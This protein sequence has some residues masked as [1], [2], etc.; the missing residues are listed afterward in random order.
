MVQAIETKNLSLSYGDS[1]II[2]ELDL[3]IPKGEITVF[4]GGN[5]C[6]KSTL[7]RSIARLL[8]PK[9]GTVLL[10]GDA[11]A[12]LSTKE[13]ARRMAILPQSPVAPEGLTVLQL[14][15]QGRYPYQSWLRQWS[16]EDE[17]K[18]EK[19]LKATG[20]T[21]LKDRS[22]DSLSGGQ[23]QRAWIAM[24]LAQDTDILLLDEPTTY[25]DLTHQIEILDLLFELNEQ[26]QRTIVM[27]L[28]D[29]N[30]A[31]RY[32]HNIVAIKDQ[33]IFAEGKPETVINCS[34]V[35]NVFGMDCEVTMDPL[36]GTP[37]CI[38]Y[39]KGRCIVKKVGAANGV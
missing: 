11:I 25:L 2:K 22:V 30:L 19:A 35:K 33:K 29:L 7:L 27:V 26:E 8:K 3:K 32:A 24:T 17:M 21:G 12:N 31:C 4:I 13:V 9:S 23:R 16:E 14:V 1:I 10:E 15:K 34:L 38:P 39:G 37:M 20:L 36:F 6:G 28:H 5:G 18:V